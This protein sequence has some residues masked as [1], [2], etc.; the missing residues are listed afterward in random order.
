MSF[1][2]YLSDPIDFLHVVTTLILC[3]VGE[4][5]EVHSSSLVWQLSICRWQA[6]RVFFA[7]SHKGISVLSRKTNWTPSSKKSAFNLY[8]SLGIFTRRQIDDIFLIFPR[9]QDLT[10]HANCLPQETICGR[11]FAWN[12][13]SCFLGKIRKMFQNVVCW[14]FYSEC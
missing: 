13:K 3:M 2:W 14:K 11:Q 9:K 1:L 6:L 8:H 10:F 7:S 12:V 4:K 5:S